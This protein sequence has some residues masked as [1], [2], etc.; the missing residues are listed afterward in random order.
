MAPLSYEDRHYRPG[1]APELRHED[2]LG[3]EADAERVHTPSPRSRSLDQPRSALP[4]LPTPRQL[5]M[6]IKDRSRSS[7]SDH[8]ADL[9]GDISH[10][11]RDYD[12]PAADA[13]TLHR[14]ASKAQ[15]GSSGHTN[16]ETRH[17]RIVPASVVADSISLANEEKLLLSRSYSTQGHNRERENRHGTVEGRQEVNHNLS[18]ASSSTLSASSHPPLLSSYHHTAV[19]AAHL[20]SAAA[21]WSCQGTWLR[22]CVTA[23]SIVS[24][25]CRP[26]CSH[27]DTKAL[28][29]DC[30]PSFPLSLFSFHN[31]SHKLLSV[32][33]NP[34]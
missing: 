22:H 2:P 14:T 17:Q 3:D 21:S 24:S 25:Y 32:L 18:L 30:I 15:N 29:M 20:R 26:P 10:Q 9:K 16:H 34:L 1:D 6:G 7:H 8:D 11:P 23:L 12:S 19:N 33:P 13:S 28:I 31:I 4:P 27:T 5:P